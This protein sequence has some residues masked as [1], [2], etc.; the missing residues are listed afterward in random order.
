MTK[1]TYLPLWHWNEG[2]ED[3]G[4]IEE[5]RTLGRF[6]MNKVITEDDLRHHQPIYWMFGLGDRKIGKA[7]MARIAYIG[8]FP[9]WA[10]GLSFI[11]ANEWFGKKIAK[12]AK[13]ISEVR[14]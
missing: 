10:F 12:F 6:A 4:M 1:E 8:V 2:L 5:Y 13:K 9:M 7:I 11:K 14:K 3:M